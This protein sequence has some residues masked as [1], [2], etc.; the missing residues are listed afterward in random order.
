MSSCAAKAAW[1]L[2]RDRFSTF[3]VLQLVRCCGRS[4]GCD[5]YTLAMGRCLVGQHISRH[6]IV[7]EP[8]SVFAMGGRELGSW[9]RPLRPGLVSLGIP[10]ITRTSCNMI[11][12]P[13]DER[14]SAQHCFAHRSVCGILL[15]IVALTGACARP[16]FLGK[17]CKNRYYWSESL[18]AK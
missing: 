7:F 10:P 13:R 5:V 6:I 15:N 2:H 16:L 12:T 4:M 14:N 17:Q 8:S 9:P 3:S 1:L 11:Y 18:S